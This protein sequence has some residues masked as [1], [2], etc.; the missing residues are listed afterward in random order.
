MANVRPVRAAGEE[1]LLGKN[2]LLFLNFGEEATEAAPKWALIGG[3]RDASYNVSADE[4]DVTDKTSGGYGDTAPGTKS[5]ELSLELIVKP[6][7]ATIGEL[8]KAFD[9]DESVDILRWSKN[10]RSIRNWYSITS[11]EESAS[12][13]DA[14]ILS[15]TLKGKGQPTYTEKMEDPR[16]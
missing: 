7:D 5:V 6:A 11:M 9:N 12:Y 3:Q 2:V 8:Y 16:G 13:D 4:I 1:K 10:G 15:V 14:A